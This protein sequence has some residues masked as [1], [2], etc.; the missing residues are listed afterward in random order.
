MSLPSDDTVTRTWVHAESQA[1]G[2]YSDIARFLSSRLFLHPG[3]YSLLDIGSRTGVGPDLL[4][5]MFHP[6]SY[7]ALKLD[8]VTAID[9]NPACEAENKARYPDIEFLTGDAFELPDTRSWDIVMSSH[10]IEHV[11]E[12]RLFLEKMRNMAARAAVVACPY[13]EE[14]RIPGHCSSISYRILTEAGYHDIEAYR[15]PFWF[16]S[17]CVIACWR[18]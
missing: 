14:E 12:P 6:H 11:P 3:T 15:S 5:R 16:N 9:I 7:A 10:T 2:F 8:P 13:H 1:L 18:R 4:R 17:L